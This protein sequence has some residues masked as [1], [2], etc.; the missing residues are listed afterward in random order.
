MNESIKSLTNAMLKL[1]SYVRRRGGLSHVYEQN[2][3]K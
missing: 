1:Q 3:G 2:N